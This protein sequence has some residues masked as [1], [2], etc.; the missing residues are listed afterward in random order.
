M[1]PVAITM[2][3]IAVLTVWGGLGLALWNLSRHPEDEEMLPK[4]M[5]H[6]L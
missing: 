1:T 2:M 6:E 4:E 3:I 5:P